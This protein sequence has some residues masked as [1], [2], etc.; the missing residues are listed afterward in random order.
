[1]KYK[2]SII[3]LLI[4]LGIIACGIIAYTVIIPNT[5]RENINNAFCSFFGIE[6]ESEQ[7][8]FKK[9][10]TNAF[11][12]YFGI[13]IESEIEHSN[14]QDKTLE[15]LLA[16]PDKEKYSELLKGE[17]YG[18]GDSTEISISNSNYKQYDLTSKK[19]ELKPYKD[20]IKIQKAVANGGCLQNLDTP[21]KEYTINEKISYQNDEFKNNWNNYCYGEEKFEDTSLFFKITGMTVMNGNNT[22]TENYNSYA[23]AKKIKV[24]FNNGEQEEIINLLDTIEA[25]FI[26]LSYTQN[27]ISKPID[28]S[29]EV[30][31][32]YNGNSSNDIYLA[33]IQFGI[34][35]NIPQGR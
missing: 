24:I 11:N 33:D 34:T 21:N 4:V 6:V 28:I 10:L 15:A 23:R 1:M 25:Q 3:K 7:E 12:A 31:E 35:S 2:N 26:D 22:S 19:G 32:T 18:I 17:T 9:D 14:V 5:W 30:L 20:I 16:N 8:K 13:T 29:I 27:D